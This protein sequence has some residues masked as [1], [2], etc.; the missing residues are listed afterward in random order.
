M[1]RKSVQLEPSCS[2][3]MDGRTDRQ[4]D[5]QTDTKMLSLSQFCERASKVAFFTT[6]LSCRNRTGNI[7]FLV[8][9]LS[10]DI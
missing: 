5:G 2:I 4:T 8:K 10:I 9:K 3:R 7:T 6:S 1:T